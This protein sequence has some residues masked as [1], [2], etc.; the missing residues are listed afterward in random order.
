MQ[1]HRPATQP[2]AATV[3]ARTLQASAVRRIWS[4]LLDRREWASYIYVPLIVPILVLA[5]YLVITYHERSE[6]IHHLVESLS[7][8]SRD[9]EKMS[10]LLESRPSP[11]SGVA[12]EEVHSI[13]AADYRGFEV[14]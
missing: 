14:L 6:Q 5:P 12:A 8:G 1:G 13:D 4:T 9:L 11:L 7:Q 10:R 3:E 2:V